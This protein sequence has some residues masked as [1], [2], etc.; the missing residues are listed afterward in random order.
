MNVFGCVSTTKCTN[1]WGLFIWW[2]MKDFSIVWY[3]Q[4]FIS[5]LFWDNRIFLHILLN[6]GTAY[7]FQ[8]RID[9]AGCVIHTSIQSSNR[10]I[11][12]EDFVAFEE[13]DF[14]QSLIYVCRMNGAS[15]YPMSPKVPLYT[16]HFDRILFGNIVSEFT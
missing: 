7:R 4:K 9:T 2:C 14:E 5:G 10:W 3:Y 13:L 6:G 8:A 15:K 16:K 1:G 12:R 11:D